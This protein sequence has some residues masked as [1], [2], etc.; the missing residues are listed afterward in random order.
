[1]PRGNVRV[2][3]TGDADG[4]QR[5]TRS[6]ERDLDRFGKSGSK[7]LSAL[8]PAALAAAGAMTALG[9]AAG[10]KAVK[11]AV[12][13]EEQMNKTRVVFRGS[14]KDIL[15]W[16]ESTATAIGVSR[17]EA[18]A[19]SSTFGNMLVP[20]GLARDE[21]AI[22]SKRFVT[23]SANLASFNNTKPAEAL[24][25]LRAG[26]AGESE[27]LRRFGVFLSETR[28]KA[29]AL[30]QGF[31]LVDGQLSE[32]AKAQ[33][34]YSLILKDSRDA[35]GDFRRTS[36]SLAN[37]QR[38]L[39]ATFED[40]SAQLGRELL[41]IL[42]D[43]ARIL[44]QFIRQ[45]RSGT[46]AG[47]D[48][49]RIMQQAWKVIKVVIDV[50]VVW[51]TWMLKL[52]KLWIQVGTTAVRWLKAIAGAAAD[53]FNFVKK[54]V[55]DVIAGVLRRF[56]TVFEVASKLPI[57]G[58]K[59]QGIA[60]KVNQT[61]DRID[62]M[63]EKIRKLPRKKEIDI[64]V[65]VALSD[66]DAGKVSPLVPLDQLPAGGPDIEGKIGQMSKKKAAAWAK[67]N[68]GRLLAQA[69]PMLG[70]PGNR[71]PGALGALE[72]IGN[73]MGLLTT[74]GYRPGDDGWHG[75]NRARDLSGS[76]GLMM[77]YAKLLFSRFG[78]RLLELIYTPMGIGIKNGQPVN[79][80]SF[81]GPAVAADHYDHVHV[82]LQR[83]GKI[84]GSRTG[85]KNLAALEDGEF[86]VNRKATAKALPFLQALNAGIPRFQ[87]GGISGAKQIRGFAERVWK[88][89]KALAGAGFE[90]R[91]P[92]ITMGGGLRG[93]VSAFHR[94]ANSIPIGK[95]LQEAFANPDS[96]SRD[97]ALRV[98]VHEMAHAAQPI[99]GM[100]RWEFEGGAEAFAK[101]ASPQVYGSLGIP[102]H[103]YPAGY[104][105]YV[106]R[107]MK[108]KSPGWIRHGQFVGVDG[109]Q[110]GG[111]VAQASGVDPGYKRLIGMA[112]SRYGIPGYILAGLI[113]V[114]SGWDPNAVSSAGAFGITQF[115]PGTAAG[116]GV[117]AGSSHGAVASQIMGAAHYLVDLGYKKDRMF[118]LAA[119]NG[120]PG[121]PQY[122]YA[123]D[124]IAASAKYK[125]ILASAGGGGRRGSE[126]E[127]SKPKP[128][129]TRG[130][131]SSLDVRDARTE[132]R[133]DALEN[134][135]NR[136]QLDRA[137]RARAKVFNQ[138]IKQKRT[139]LARI[140]RALRGR[141][142]RSTRQRLLAEKATLV[143]DINSDIGSLKSLTTE[144]QER[145]GGGGVTG[146][147][148]SGLTGL[149]GNDMAQALA[150][151]TPGTEDDL[152]ALR[153]R[154]WHAGVALA[155]NQQSGNVEGI[156]EWANELASTREAIESLTGAMA[157]ANRLQQER[158]A[159]NQEI[160]DN[161]RKLLLY[162][163]TQG[164]ALIGAV[165]AAANGGI[166]GKFGLGNQTPSFAGVGGLARY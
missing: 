166:G 107:V 112:S 118:A 158:D 69:A 91:M 3:I 73:R 33:A 100:K 65:K 125:G 141:L 58:D 133:W 101:W 9:A 24:E 52:P 127:P 108:E 18:L 66:L 64:M 165:V 129:P 23:L 105:G 111:L 15:K 142:T 48:F 57:I 10:V 34:R 36:D 157:E 128:K 27:P 93:G 139:R 119:Y 71:A 1:V 151:L 29:E 53:T 63:G 150:R 16:S 113:E 60:D 75:Q 97:Y 83:G 72:S 116:Y 50:L 154:E 12:D 104:P 49:V 134:S 46:G 130:P 8:K 110:N 74:S 153:A 35:Q 54:I 38:V 126:E 120:G 68:A 159:I 124:V 79:I 95:V 135:T 62:R 6:A 44:V 121:N 90:E 22:M 155:M 109:F 17:R 82:A 162:A 32:S 56:A 132:G 115:M 70:A 20:M 40:V 5:A 4:L 21:A 122:G 92:S 31:K 137:Y 45:M 67:K 61:A 106:S 37:Q 28:V 30:R 131:S 160:V 14:E 78:S 163:S 77:Q 51:N 88:K 136:R 80:Q 98:L 146:D 117:R 7:A 13:L 138:R 26:L 114:E 147:A 144:F 55:G 42:T 47:G 41:P 149:E 94:K 145:V 123:H 81:Y 164:P 87:E 89:T 84:P 11:A 43:G 140:N 96:L 76:A 161:Q 85:D 2:S 156:T 152:A 102:Y 59:F 39:R 25:A 148:E 143:R 99:S 103:D 86:V 19:A